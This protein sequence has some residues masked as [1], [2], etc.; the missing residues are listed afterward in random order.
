MKTS[1]A[2][3]AKA[4]VAGR[5]KTRLVPALTPEAAARVA[6]GCLEISIRRFVP[7]V[8]APF[9]LFVEGT[10]DAELLELAASVR[11]PIVPQAGADLGA[12]LR[13]AF[14]A[15]RAGGAD[16]T[17][18]VGSDSPTLDPARI[19]EAVV[20]LESHQAV[21]GPAEDGG[22]YLI[23]VR[24]DAPGM[25][26]GIPWS[27]SDVARRTLER[28]ADLGMSVRCLPAWY[29][30]DDLPS[31]ERAIADVDPRYRALIELP[32]LST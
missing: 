26:E 2:M 27:T 29:D 22:Y 6:R 7:A 28:A 12:R 4:P 25:F 1:I 32:A 24:G 10:S 18:A 31:L 3:L 19:R 23:G 16:A 17:I 30:V 5:V 15:L 11:V 9:T 20:A 13:A 8:P 14:A 21:L